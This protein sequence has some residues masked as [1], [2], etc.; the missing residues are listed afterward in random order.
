MMVDDGFDKWFMK[1]LYQQES[2]FERDVLR[3]KHVKSEMRIVWRGLLSELEP[4]QI[5]ARKSL[6]PVRNLEN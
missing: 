4:E 5:E 6:T 1:L 3:D 2:C